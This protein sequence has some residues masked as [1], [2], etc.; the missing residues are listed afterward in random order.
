MVQL[1]IFSLLKKILDTLPVP[2]RE[3][4]IRSD[5]SLKWEAGNSKECLLCDC[6][7][8]DDC[9][10]TGKSWP[11]AQGWSRAISLSLCLSHPHTLWHTSQRF[12]KS[13]LTW[14]RPC[15]SN[16][17]AFESLPGTQIFIALPFISL[18]NWTQHTT[19]PA[20]QCCQNKWWNFKAAMK[21][22]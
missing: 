7:W 21:Y 22:I 18:S 17:D 19:Y 16:G 15:R 2:H 6:A 12:L 3:M 11:K 5:T 9:C 10:S 4:T 8:A 13:T 1:Q 20:C 14:M